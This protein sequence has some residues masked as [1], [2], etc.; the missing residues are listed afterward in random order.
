V[1][2]LQ[3][4]FIVRPR[5]APPQPMPALPPASPCFAPIKSLSA[6][7]KFTLHHKEKLTANTTLSVLL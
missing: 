6:D 3:T 1:V 5:C 4:I 2:D 7:E